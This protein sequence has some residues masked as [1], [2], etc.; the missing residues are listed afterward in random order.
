[1]AFPVVFVTWI[2]FMA[3]WELG[4]VSKIRLQLI[5][6]QRPVGC[7][8]SPWGDFTCVLTMTASLQERAMIQI[9][10]MLFWVR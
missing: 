1:M 2:V 5:L 4:R 7:S 9:P 10:E 3:M 8:G 6:F